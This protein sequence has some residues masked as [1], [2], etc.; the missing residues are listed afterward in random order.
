MLHEELTVLL[1]L[2]K[3]DLRN[4]NKLFFYST[5]STNTRILD[6]LDQVCVKRFYQIFVSYGSS[7]KTVTAH[8]MDN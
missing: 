1:A 7:N 4:L 6:M 8:K 5:G 3:K 2:P